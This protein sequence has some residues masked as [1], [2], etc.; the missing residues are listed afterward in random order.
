MEIQVFVDDGDKRVHYEISCGG[1][2][3]AYDELALPNFLVN[4]PSHNYVIMEI[5]VEDE[6]NDMVSR[7]YLHDGGYNVRYSDNTIR[8]VKLERSHVLLGA[9]GV[10]QADEGGMNY[11]MLH[12]GNTM[13]P[14]E[15]KI[16]KE[17]YDWVD[18]DTYTSKG[19]PNFDKVENP[20]R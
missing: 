14:D 7:G 3:T 17:P 18:P 9:D 5:D 4:P 15:F 19:E 13:D 20:G 10:E 16:P 11:I 1:Y 2:V 12:V 6:L 8:E